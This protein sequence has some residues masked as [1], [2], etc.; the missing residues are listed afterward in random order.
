M[1][2][3]FEVLKNSV[4]TS[5]ISC[6]QDSFGKMGPSLEA[7]VLL[8]LQMVVYSIAPQCF[9]SYFQM[10]LLIARRACYEFNRMIPQLIATEYTRVPTN[11]D[12][13]GSE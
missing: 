11:T 2:W 12:F 4:D 9:I 3:L 1:K 13:H 10:S 5:F 8:P 7:K 6:R